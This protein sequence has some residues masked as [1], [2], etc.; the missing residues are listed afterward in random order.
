[1]TK[2]YSEAITEVLDILD[3]TRIQDVEKIPKGFINFLNK[4]CAKDYYPNLDYTKTINEIEIK[5]E[6]R[7]ILGTIYRNWWCSKEEKENYIKIIQSK[8]KLFQ[9]EIR[10]KYNP[11]TLFNKKK[12]K[13]TEKNNDKVQM[14]KFKENIL[15]KFLNKIIRILKRK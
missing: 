15:K 4:N 3:H 12:Q 14:I 13:Y 5:P 9:Q 2:S 6:T 11:D 7:A 10:E 8:E 1:M